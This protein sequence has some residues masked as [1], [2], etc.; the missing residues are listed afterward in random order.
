MC[1]FTTR[2]QSRQVC[3]KYLY[4]GF[5]ECAP[6][7]RVRSRSPYLII[8]VYCR[9][10]LFIHIYYSSTY[11]NVGF[12]SDYS[13]HSGRSNWRGIDKHFNNQP[14]LRESYYSLVVIIK[15]Y[16]CFSYFIGLLV[17]LLDQI[18]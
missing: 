5:W 3:N 10:T 4:L 6:A 17:L 9:F 2:L 1:M 12:L 13:S 8:F 11:Y 18:I 7:K 15:Y 16:C 14:H